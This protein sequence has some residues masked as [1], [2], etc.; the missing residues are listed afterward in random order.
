MGV[1]AKERKR[2]G[3]YER[4]ERLHQ[5]KSQY[6]DGQYPYRCPEERAFKRSVTG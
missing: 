1:A 3:V 5:L 4:V 6:L 2:N